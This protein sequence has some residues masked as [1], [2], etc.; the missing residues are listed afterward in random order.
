MA[1]SAAYR[2]PQEHGGGRRNHIVQFIH[3][4]LLVARVVHGRPI[5]AK[6]GCD[7]VFRPGR[8]ELIRRELFLDELIVGFVFVEGTNHVIP[9]APRMGTIVIELETATI[10]VTGEIEPVPSPSFAVMR[11]SQQAIDYFFKSVSGAIRKKRV[12][13]LWRWREPNQV[14]IYA[15]Q[16]G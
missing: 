11:R 13:I 15:P 2:Q 8:V 5:A 16:E 7:Q 4:G 12:Y 14:E 1:A 6:P 3:P 10:S 9:V